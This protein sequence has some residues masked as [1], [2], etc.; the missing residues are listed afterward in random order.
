MTSV[1]G[2]WEYSVGL[3][4]ILS[5]ERLFDW[6]FESFEGFLRISSKTV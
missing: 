5:L 2:L 3:H 1:A 6:E 4:G